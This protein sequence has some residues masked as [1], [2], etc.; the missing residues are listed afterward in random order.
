MDIKYSNNKYWPIG[1]EKLRHIPQGEPFI[2]MFSGGKDSS[3]ALSMACQFGKAVALI[4]CM[5]NEIHKSI[6]HM[7][8]EALVEAQALTMNI[9]IFY[10]YKHWTSWVNLVR[11]YRAYKNQGVKFVVFGDLF[12]EDNAKLQAT[13]CQSAGLIP[14]MPLWL[15]PHEKIL[16]EIEN[17][18]IISIITV[19]ESSHISNY[20][21]GKVFDRTVYENFTKLDVD[22]FGEYGEYHTTTV[23]ADI[24]KTPIKYKLNKINEKQIYL[25][26]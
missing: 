14:C 20:W 23:D 19:I 6:F 22:P 15:L 12:R 11:I 21:L 18:K 17:R 3:L 4:H 13:L 16:Q 26:L 24:F 1:N 25:Q 10:Y 7:Q 2:C 9:P 8:S 5:N